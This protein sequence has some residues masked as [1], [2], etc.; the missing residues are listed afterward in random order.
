MATGPGSAIVSRIETLEVQIEEDI[1]SA[2]DALTTRIEVT[3]AGIVA[4][5]NAITTTNVTVNGISANTAFRA[6]SSYAPAAGYAARIGLE[7]RTGSTG[8]YR[9][10]AI[11]IDVPAVTSAP[12]RVAI[13]ADQFVVTSGSN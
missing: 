7:A 2:V 11:F 6:S 8:T 9:S 13:N 10:A 1:A 5:A 12:T 4:N 3:E